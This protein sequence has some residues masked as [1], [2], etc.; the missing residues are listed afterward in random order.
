MLSEVRGAGFRRSAND[1]KH[2]GQQPGSAG[3]KVEMSG[4]YRYGDPGSDTI[5]HL[6]TGRK[7][8]EKCRMPR[9]EKDDPKLGDVC[10]RLSV[11]LC[12]SKGCDVPICNLHRVKHASKPNTDFCTTHKEEAKR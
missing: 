12:D 9:F 7:Q 10:G 1:S 8:Y 11:A 3:G 4:F 2:D 6:N 5:A